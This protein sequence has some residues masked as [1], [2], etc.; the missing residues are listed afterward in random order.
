MSNAWRRHKREVTKEKYLAYCG[1]KRCRLCGISHLPIYCY[2]FHHIYDKDFNIS[3][4]IN[5]G[6]PVEAIKDELDKCVVL[7]SNCHREVHHNPVRRRE[8]MEIVGEAGH[9]DNVIRQQHIL[10][11]P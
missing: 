2:D 9:G 10:H 3:W 4:A 5:K 6:L 8:L 11:L 1:G 7:C